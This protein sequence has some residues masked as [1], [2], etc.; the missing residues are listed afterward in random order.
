MSSDWTDR[1]VRGRFVAPAPAKRDLGLLRPA[2]LRQLRALGAVSHAAAG[3]VVAAADSFVTHVQIV[4][5]GQ[6]ELRARP[7]EGS[8]VQEDP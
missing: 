2:E 5:A 1:D 3:T 7:A 4:G 6:L 8:T